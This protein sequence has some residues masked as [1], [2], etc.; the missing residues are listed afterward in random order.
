MSYDGSAHRSQTSD[1]LAEVFRK[2]DG[3]TEQIIQA[4]V[5]W[6]PSYAGRR[7]GMSD[8]ASVATLDAIPDVL[9]SP[10]CRSSQ[11]ISGV[12]DAPKPERLVG[13]V[14]FPRYALLNVIAMHRRSMRM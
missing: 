1:R 8:A 4:Q 12:T 5:W 9:R 7:T 10:A 6:Q 2:R 3:A 13:I 11:H 14:H